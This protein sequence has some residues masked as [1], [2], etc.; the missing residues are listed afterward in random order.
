MS[1]LEDSELPGVSV[2]NRLTELKIGGRLSG[3]VGRGVALV[4][5]RDFSLQT[6]LLSLLSHW[7][8][9]ILTIFCEPA[10]VC[11]LMT[12][13]SDLQVTLGLLLVL[14]LS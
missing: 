10:G 5:W 14:V 1:V 2:T 6:G 3:A 13:G 7:L 12:C 4:L 11:V 8:H 9:L